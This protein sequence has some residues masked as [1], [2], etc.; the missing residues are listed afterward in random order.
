MFADPLDDLNSGGELE[1]E[2]DPDFPLLSASNSDDSDDS[3]LSVMCKVVSFR[4]SG[5]I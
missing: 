3:S 2:E 1:I 4:I 5:H